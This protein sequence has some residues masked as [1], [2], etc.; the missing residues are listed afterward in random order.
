MVNQI[1]ISK[2]ELVSQLIVLL[3]HFKTK[4]FELKMIIFRF[5]TAWTNALHYRSIEKDEKKG[6]SFE[7]PLGL[8]KRG[9]PTNSTHIKFYYY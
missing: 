1:K 8:E 9:E 3:S 4:A 2:S 6:Q 7:K 5:V